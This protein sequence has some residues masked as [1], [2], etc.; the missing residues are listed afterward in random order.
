VGDSLPPP[1]EFDLVGS[2]AR[3]R[4]SDVEIVLADPKTAVSGSIV[5]RLARGKRKVDAKGSLDTDPRGR[6]LVA[7][8]PRSA[9]ADGNWS[10]TL[11]TDDGSP[12]P[13]AARLL[14]QGDRPLVLLWGAKD[15]PTV[16]PD[17]RAVP[18]AK[19]RAAAAGG[20]ALDRVL[21]VLPDDR[22]KQVRE[23]ARSAARKVLG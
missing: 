10:L 20:R 5:V 1:A 15:K 11:L 18:S 12:E 21:S 6:R 17:N 22:A 4:G 13:L 8:A 3:R 19:R 16:E 7:R 14:V 9:F 23:R 2:Y